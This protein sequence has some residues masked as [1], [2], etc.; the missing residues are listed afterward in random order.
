MI[1]Q[2]KDLIIMKLWA[3]GA[4][5][6]NEDVS[7]KFVD[8]GYVKLGWNEDDAPILY[9]L[10]RKVKVGDFIY[11]KS[12]AMNDHSIRIKAIG[13]VTS[14]DDKE[15]KVDWKF[16]NQTPIKYVLTK[17]ED[18]YN[19]YPMSFYREYSDDIIKIVRENI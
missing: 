3:I 5:W 12:F 13:M 4:T 15:M 16:K 18:R 6:G 19:V 2:R 17:N 1:R 10:F 7:A 9:K 14:N 11:I 8:E